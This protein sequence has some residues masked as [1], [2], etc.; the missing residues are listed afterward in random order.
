MTEPLSNDVRERLVSAVDSGLSQR[1]A[2]QRFG[3]ADCYN[4]SSRGNLPLDHQS[5]AG[6]TYLA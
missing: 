2:A 4:E 1:S 5:R 6:H 3:I